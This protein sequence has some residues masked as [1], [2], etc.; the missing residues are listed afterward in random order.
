MEKNIS[1]DIFKSYDVRGIYP[2]ELNESIAETIGQAAVQYFL[3]KRKKKELTVLICRD[4]RLSSPSLKEAVSR[5]V[6]LAGSNV[7][8]VGIGT[9]PFFY[10]LMHLLKPDVGFMITASHNPA[11]YNGIKIRNHLGHPVS[12]DAG[13]AEIRELALDQKFP[14]AA[15]T[16]TISQPDKD[17]AKAYIDFLVKQVGTSVQSRVVVDAGGGATTF[18]LPDLLNRFPKILYKPLFFEPDGSFAKHPPNPL[19]PTSQK[20]PARELKNGDFQFGVIFDA[21]GDRAVFLDEAGQ[22]VR[23][24]FILAVLAEEELKKNPGAVFVLPVNT[25]KAAREYIAEH[26]GKVKLS[27]IGT[28]NIPNAMRRTRANLAGETSG[29]FYFKEF[30]HN[31][32]AFLA[33]LR[34][35]KLLSSRDGLPLS[36]LTRPLA[37]R[38]FTHEANFRVA[39]PHTILRNVENF[40]QNLSGTISQ[41][42]GTTVEFEDWWFNL[43]P[44][45]TEPLVRL[46]IEAKAEGLMKEKR[47]EIEA[48]LKNS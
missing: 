10:F 30:F 29:H 36:A 8:D 34:V 20:Y 40:Y 22:F 18:F 16:G 28:A 14:P 3:K 4:V 5:G 31:D 27:K 9:T 6:I 2:R 41:L 45:N 47:Q 13:L 43:R 32:S 11:E 46:I 12:L 44:S 39:D 21:D 42:D 17:L 19:E 15:R 26:G 33:F 24:E 7:L 38:Y 35:A 37:S 48:L 1:P 23:S 25:S